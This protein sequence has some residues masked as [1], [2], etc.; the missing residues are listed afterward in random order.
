[1]LMKGILFFFVANRL[2]HFIWII[3]NSKIYE[4]LYML[5]AAERFFYISLPPIIV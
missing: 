4:D 1:M 2:D 5:R 3:F